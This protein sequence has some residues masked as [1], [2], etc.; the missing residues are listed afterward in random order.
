MKI[1]DHKVYIEPFVGGG[2]L[3]WAKPS[4]QK[5]II[6]D[7][8]KDLIAGYKVLKQFSK[9]EKTENFPIQKTLKSIQALVDKP[10]PDKYERLLGYLYQSCNT[11]GNTGQGLIYKN[12]TRH[13]CRRA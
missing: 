10:Y 12:N 6:N 7:L 11:F 8:D 2:S 13:R 5:A 1:S 3:F 4:S 9:N